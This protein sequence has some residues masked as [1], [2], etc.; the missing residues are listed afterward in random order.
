MKVQVNTPTVVMKRFHIN[1]FCPFLIT[2]VVMFSICTCDVRLFSIICNVHGNHMLPKCS[3]HPQFTTKC[4]S[5]SH[6]HL[7]NILFTHRIV[8]ALFTSLFIIWSSIL[9]LISGDVHPNP[10]PLSASNSSVSSSQSISLHNSINA[11]G[12]FSFVH[13]NVQSIINKLDILRTE[14]TEFD[15]LAFS[16]TWL[17]QSIS[18]SDLLF[19][20]Y[21]LPERKDRDDSH[22][23]VILYIRD[24]ISY[25]RRH[26]LEPPGV[27]CIWV[28]LILHHK[29]VLFGLFYRPPS[30]DNEYYTKI[31][32]SIHLAIDTNI[33][34]VVI[35]GDFNYNM[36]NVATSRKIDS[37]CQ[38]YSLH[39]CITEPTNFTEHSQSIIDII[40]VK[41]KQNILLSGVGEPILQ[42][43]IRFH[44][45]IFGVLN[46][47]KPIYKS[48]TRQIWSYDKG[49]YN[50][51][52]T[53]ARNTDW[54]SLYNVDVNTHAKNITDH[55]INITKQ[56]VPNKYVRIKPQDLPWISSSIK[57][58]IRK[59]KRAYKKAK[60]TNSENHWTKF[61]KLRNNV[62]QLLR[63][64]KD[65]H[66]LKLADK[67][68][69]DNRNTK[70]WW[71]TMKSVINTNTK[72]SIPPLQHNDILLSDDNDKA[73]LLNNFFRDQTLVNDSNIDVPI[74]PT[75]NHNNL[76]DI[77]LTPLEVKQ[78]LQ[79]LA[80]GKAVGPDSVNNIIL[81][82]LS[83]ELA[84]PICTLFNHSLQTGIVPSTWK[85]ANVCS[86]FKSGDA[87]LVSNYRPISLLSSLE[88]A[89][90]KNIFKHFFNFLQD[91]N[92]ITSFQSG[93]IPGDSTTNQLVYLYN[94]FCQSID[95]G[96]EVRAIF[97]D[98][99]KAFD[100]VWHKGLLIKLQAAGITGNLLSWFENYL[101]NRKQR[102]VLPGATSDWA[103]IKA[104]VPQ[105]SI[106][107][108]LLFLLYINDIV[109]DINSNIR[110]FADDTGLF[111]VVDDP[112]TSANTL[113]ADLLKIENWA[114]KWLVR[115]NPTKTESLLLSRKSNHINHPPVFMNNHLISEVKEHKH[116]GVFLSHDLSWHKQI[117]YIKSKAWK[118]VNIM[119][120]LKFKLDRVSLET[121]YITFIRP[122]L[123]YGDILFDNCTQQEKYELDKIQNEAARVVTGA[124]KLVSID[125]LY[126]ETR[127][128]SLSQR[129]WMHKL[130]Q[131]YK[132]I[133]GLSPEFLSNLTP[134]TVGSTSQYALRN[135]N[136]IQTIHTRA[137]N[138]Y[139]SFLPSA[140][141]E[142]NAL[143]ED[144][145]N[146]ESVLVFKNALKRHLN[147]PP[148]P[149]YFL[150]GTRK[151]QIIHTR[152]Q[153]NC[154]TLSHDLFLK[155]MTDSP[156]CVCGVNEDTDHFLL[157]CCLYLDLRDILIRSIPTEI[158]ITTPL[159]LFGD[160]N[161][162]YDTNI[163]I[164]SAVH[165]YIESTHR[166]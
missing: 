72:S 118:R 83:S 92:I 58:M 75:L 119:R 82:E 7:E 122:I 134:P 28:E 96:K 60:R 164:F 74:L 1:A 77:V 156:L 109:N 139:N 18:S 100:R 4:H 151:L 143:S 133:K 128:E 26:D 112:I 71:S 126:K 6:R 101:C 46:F 110:L 9:L 80:I 140:V 48:Y 152:L 121:V 124:T 32:D 125:H 31:D 116:L 55:I 155:N 159:L 64:G 29:H 87:S 147:I 41:N 67:L 138:H 106:L 51:L 104:G 162:S 98:I 95:S 59:R 160:E 94:F 117:E 62:I 47:K 115:F 103:C 27:E 145:R 33:D 56:C 90:E 81:R 136:N 19:N 12:H 142:W 30:S 158:E 114:N 11:S 137:S 91:N 153:T 108:P 76:T 85:E 22:G 66:F 165:N 120:S 105:G 132:M 15:I 102:V 148:I 107:G 144:I 34:D 113:N 44:C 39:Q 24:N 131:F 97:C 70:S 61:R 8:C 52:K 69:T 163:I 127:W 89:L 150:F 93:F 49:D 73:N 84:E 3:L 25:K 57:N 99:S 65:D 35:S 111:I 5:L 2:L 14:L 43:D 157:R 149:K 123:E 68:K 146:S 37:L 21:S 50:H 13:Y 38:Q 79:T 166:F 53:L 23:G 130:V 20:S 45:P 161:L 154:S 63:K 86:I 36:S 141:R 88:K 10:G 135:S 16:E 42:Q 40:L 17:N 54:N 78:I 129:R